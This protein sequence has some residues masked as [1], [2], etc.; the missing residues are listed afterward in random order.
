VQNYVLKNEQD[1]ILDACER[2]DKE[3]FLKE[4]QPSLADAMAEK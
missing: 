1:H 3:Q 4:H 2:D